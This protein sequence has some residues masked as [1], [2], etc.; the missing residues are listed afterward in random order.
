MGADGAPAD[1]WSSSL[2]SVVGAVTETPASGAESS[3]GVVVGVSRSGSS[4]ELLE[5][6]VVV[7]DGLT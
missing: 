2:T 6:V 4:E 1:E 5:T 3:R 7:R